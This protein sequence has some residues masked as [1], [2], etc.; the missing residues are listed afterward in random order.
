MPI[1]PA[2]QSAVEVTMRTA[3]VLEL[4]QAETFEETGAATAA[5][6]IDSKQEKTP[7]RLREYMD[8]SLQV[9]CSS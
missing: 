2:T 7:I 9:M 1:S 3:P 8:T 4:T 5:V 6:A